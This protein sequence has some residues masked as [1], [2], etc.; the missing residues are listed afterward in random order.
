[1]RKYNYR[2]LQPSGRI[3]EGE[4][5]AENSEAVESVIKNRDGVVISVELSSTNS[6]FNKEIRLLKPRVGLA[7]LAI[8][9][10]QMATMLGAGLNIVRALDIIHQQTSNKRLK[11]ISKEMSLEIQK[12]NTLST[13]MG[14]Y[15]D[16]FP[17]LM[18]TMIETGE[19]TGQMNLAF[20][21]LNVHYTKEAKIQKGIKGAMV[22]PIVL[23]IVGVIILSIVLV[24]VVPVFISLY[25]GME[26]PLMTR[27]LL[28]VSY[29]FK[30]YWYIILAV[31]VAIFVALKKAVRT[32]K[33]KKIYDIIIS[34]L[35][36][37]RKSANIITTSRFSRTFGTLISSG[38]S[39]ISALNMATT[40][41][42]NKILAE[43]MEIVVEGIQKG[44]T[45][46][47]LLK[48]SKFFPPMMVSM[49]TIGEES[50][51][52]D[53]MMKKTADYYDEELE[54]AVS[55]MLTLIEP[56]MIL[57]MGLLIGFMVI[58]IMAP[59]FTLYSK[60]SAT[61]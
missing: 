45:L 23:A 31:I 24:Y 12:G 59:V 42:N 13:A 53:S 15:Y 16:V 6:I 51:D 22:Y 39:I 25:V 47:A 5:D 2:E 30:S 55:T 11:A 37:I 10:K 27:A 17:S 21:N 1:M 4:M 50:G 26:L 48:E 29:I 9:S 56:I 28:K 19:L 57:I 35:P 7:E 20:E 3:V 32:N 60:M 34:V 33:G 14:K 18:L 44:R 40:V 36:V 58:A 8:F 49:V 46:G 38:V 41:T 52:L 54:S 43:K 61:F